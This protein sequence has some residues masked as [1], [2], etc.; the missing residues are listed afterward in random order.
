MGW[1][2]SVSCVLWQH[3]S[4]SHMTLLTSTPD[5]K[6]NLL[7]TIHSLPHCKSHVTE[8]Q[9][10]A[11][12]SSDWFQIVTKLRRGG[13]LFR[14]WRNND[15]VQGWIKWSQLFDSCLPERA[16]AVQREWHFLLSALL[17]SPLN[18][19]FLLSAQFCFNYI[20]SRVMSNSCVISLIKWEVL[21]CPIEQ[22]FCRN[23]EFCV[24]ILC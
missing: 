6:P 12:F 11:L 17:F 15:Q 19:F 23:Q 7:P 5:R 22:L 24:E 20:L 16:Q 1:N 10:A 13:S 8:C 21:M 14:Q 3:W 18:E 4:L 9:I 2:W